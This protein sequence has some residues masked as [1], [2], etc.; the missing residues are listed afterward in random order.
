M[1][2]VFY[3]SGHGLGRASR[4]IELIHALRTLR[5]EMRILVRTAA[6]RWLSELT[7]GPA[8]DVQM[9]ETDTGL[10]Q[11]DSLR[12]DEAATARGA[13]SFYTDFDRRVAEE[14]DVLRACRA[15]LVIGDIPP[16]AFAAAARAGVP[17]VAVANF[18]TS[19]SPTC[20]D[21]SVVVFSGRTMCSRA[22]GRTPWTHCSRSR[23]R[24]SVPAWTA[25]K[26]RRKQ[27]SIG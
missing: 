9:V 19:S 26:W 18:T 2:I 10:A 3:I 1:Q 5:P 4:A 7:A 14:G 20:R 23:L 6:P 27:S 25:L 8:V 13:A 11:L 22:G 24:R 12:F 16:L 15:T 21:C 17:S